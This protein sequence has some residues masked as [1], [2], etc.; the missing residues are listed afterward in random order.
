VS[1]RIL[2]DPARPIVLIPKRPGSILSDLIA[3]GLGE[4]GAMLPYSPL[5]HLLLNALQ[6]P[7]V[8]TSAN[9]SGE[10]VLTDN[11]DVES[12]MG[13]VADAFLHNNR[14]IVRPADDSVY[15]VIAGS[16]RPMRL[17]RGGVPLEFTLERPMRVPTLAVGGHMKSTIALA[18]D[19]RVVVSPHIGDLGTLRS[20]DVFER[21]IRDLQTLYGVRAERVVTDAHPG[22][23]SRRWAQR[24]GM[25]VVH[26]FH[27]HAH[28]SALAGEHPD[29]RRWLT[30]TWDAVGYGEDGALWGGE[31]FLGRPGAWQRVATMR[32]FR[33]PGG[34]RTALE[35]W[36]SACALMWE[37]GG[38]WKDAPDGARML[39]G[40]W[41]RAINTHVTSSVGRLFD[42]AA[43]IALGL[44]RTSFD[45][46]GPMQLEALAQQ[47]ASA[48]ETLVLPLQK[49]RR[50]LWE[51]D[52][53]PLLPHLLLREHSPAQ[54]AATFHQSLAQ[55]LVD[56][57]ERVQGDAGDVTVGLCGG[58]FQNR[59]LTE[60]VAERLAAIG[61]PLCLT[62]AL[63]CNDAGLS[64][65][66]LIEL[67]ARDENHDS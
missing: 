6:R 11:D 23:A 48:N 36:R 10:P 46:Q 34:D 5:H 44:H 60:D 18:W 24:G 13:H 9:V 22:Y 17:G 53:A 47:S 3:P 15:R 25:P 38:V 35:P 61:V 31:A 39:E 20:V 65:G 21:L 56:V 26:V 8:V 64:F 67:H 27:H 50:G 63:P 54:R 57:V 32:P 12:R 41:R 49:N 37:T 52:W 28:A 45:G 16:A 2:F 51:T 43:A 42:A 1:D 14:R 55:A 59:L 33:L 66:Q 62:A 4:V 30:F 40:I 7:L 29:V 19:N 58:V